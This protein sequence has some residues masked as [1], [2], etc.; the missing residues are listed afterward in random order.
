MRLVFEIVRFGWLC[1]KI[2]LLMLIES[3]WLIRYIIRA[4]Q[5]KHMSKLNFQLKTLLV[6]ST[7]LITA[8]SALARSKKNKLVDMLAAPINE[9]M[10][11]PPIDQEVY[12]APDEACDI[13]LTKFIQSAQKSIDIAIFDINL[14]KL[15]HEI[16]VQTKKK[17]AVRIVVDRRQA[18]APHSLVPLLIKAG[19][20][21]RIGR[22]RG[23]MHNKFTIVDGKM[24]ETGSFNYTNGAAFKN[25][26]NQVYLATPSIVERY[27]KRFE[28]LWA[29]GGAAAIQ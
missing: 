29:E 1:V 20:N 2:L 26:E 13:K 16:L 7:L 8:N 14:D 21:V 9:A 15:V 18:K 23:I 24:I 22:Q 3:L 12:F 17:I 11:K 28:Q 19:A 4:I 6:I 10:V 5:R 27:R 25:N